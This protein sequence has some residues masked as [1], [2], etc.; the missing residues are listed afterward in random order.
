[1]ENGWHVK[2]SSPL[3]EEGRS[4]WRYVR[5]R[6]S[7][8]G[9]RESLAVL[10]TPDLVAARLDH[11]DEGVPST[12]SGFAMKALAPLSNDSESALIHGT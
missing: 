5:T 11:G 8:F 12:S 10:L 6:P 2:T 1:M 4:H 9:L 7:E 3:L